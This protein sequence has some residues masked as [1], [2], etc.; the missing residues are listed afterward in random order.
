[1]RLCSLAISS[2]ISTRKRRIEV[3][4]RLVEQEGRRLAHD[5]AAH[6]DALALAAR[7]L[8][9]SPVEEGSDLQDVGSALPPVF[10]VEAWSAP[11]IFRPK[12]M[13]SATLIC[14]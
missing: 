2:R 7:Q 11:R 1:M 4:K 12:A 10:A 8:G 3:G 6:G 5:G 13:F 14:G 9:G